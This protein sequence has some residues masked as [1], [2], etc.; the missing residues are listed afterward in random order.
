MTTPTPST[1][2]TVWTIDTAHS[3]VEF[4]VRHMMISNVKGRFNKV[5]GTIKDVAADPTLSSVAVEVDPASVNTGDEKRDGHLKS[6]DFFD[7]ENFPL[8]TFKSTRI[9]GRR[10]NF[11]VTGDLTIKDQTRPITLQATFNGEGKSPFGHTAASFT[12]TTSL[13]RKEWGLNW[14]VALETGG[15]LVSDNIKLEMEI[16][17]V[18]QQ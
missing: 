5:Q 16:Q 7:V 9:E 17:A 15:V 12:A 18:K 1:V 13:N 10:E 11:T 6:A 3:V 2:S 14:N 8:I 4:S